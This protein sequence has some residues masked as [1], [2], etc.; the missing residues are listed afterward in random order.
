MIDMFGFRSDRSKRVEQT[1]CYECGA[2]IVPEQWLAEVYYGSGRHRAP[3][4]VCVACWQAHCEP[5]RAA[6]DLALMRALNAHRAEGVSF[7]AIEDNATLKYPWMLVENERVWP[8]ASLCAVFDRHG[9][10]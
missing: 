10:P 1:D 8:N 7:D 5:E 3:R 2:P 6:R 9:A 4:Y